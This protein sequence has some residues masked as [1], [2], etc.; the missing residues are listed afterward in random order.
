MASS[1]QHYGLIKPAE[2]ELYDVAN[3]NANMDKI[4]EELFKRGKTINGNGPDA[5]GNWNMNEVQFAHQLVTD[6][7][8]QMSGEFLFRTTGGDASLSDGD[9]KLVTLFGRRTHTGAT[10]EVLNMQVDAVARSGSDEPI[11][12]VIDRDT[13]VAYVATSG[14]ITLTYTDAWSANPV[15]YGIT[16]TGTPVS[17]DKIIIEYVKEERG[18]ITQSDPSA[19]IS[20][21]WNLYN[22]TNGYARVKKYSDQYG[23]LIGGAY[24]AVKFSETLTGAKTTISPVS[25]YF[26]IPSDGYVWVTGGKGNNSGGDGTYILMTWSDWGEGYDGDWMAYSEDE[27][28]ISAIM[29]NF[30]YGLMQVAGVADEINFGMQM[31]ISQIQRMAYTAENLAA[32]KASGREWE[33]DENYIYI[34]KA[35]PDIYLFSDIF[36]A[37][38][39][40]NTYALG[41]VHTHDGA[42]YRCISAISTAEAWNAAHWTEYGNYTAYDHGEEIIEGGTVEVFAQT[43]YGRNLVD[44]LRHDVPEQIAALN[45]KLTTKMDSNVISV[46]NVEFY[47]VNYGL[48]GSSVG[49]TKR[50]LQSVNSAY[51]I[52]GD[53]TDYVRLWRTNDS[54][55]GLVPLATSSSPVTIKCILIK[56]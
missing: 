46:E 40:S 49:T 52:G 26:T 39:S 34:V 28:D 31:A 10:A 25:G 22:H 44:Y 50:I 30:P 42:T 20:T 14:T 16:V 15:L 21:G 29:E 33:A 9:A 48:W 38:S 36:T 5:N 3:D 1:T 4:D 43:L 35:T 12:A 13:F 45:S 47:F 55:T 54:N 8:Q 51:V 18:T 11:T 41:A 19:F 23:F 32:A 17:G 2:N 56:I 53:G 7:A 37:Y 6:D 27:I 24:T